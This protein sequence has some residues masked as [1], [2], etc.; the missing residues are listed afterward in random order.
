MAEGVRWWQGK[1]GEVE[2]EEE[3]V[4]VVWKKRRKAE[5]KK[6]RDRKRPR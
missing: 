3:V 5:E 4:E 6:E 1:E 2:V